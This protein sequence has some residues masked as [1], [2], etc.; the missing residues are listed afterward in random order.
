MANLIMHPK[1]G[2][3]I[4][5]E[6]FAGIP[7][8]E[9]T[10]Y[11]MI[12]AVFV[13]LCRWIQYLDAALRKE[14][15]SLV[16]VEATHTED[17][18]CQTSYSR[19]RYG[20]LDGTYAN[21][22]DFCAGRCRHNSESV[23]HENAYISEFHHCYSVPSNSSGANSTYL[24]GRLNGINILVGR[25][26]KSC[27]SVC[28]SNGQSCVPNK[29]PVLNQCDIMQKYMRSEGDCLASIG[30][31][32][33]AEVVDS[34][35]KHLTERRIVFILVTVRIQEDVCILE[36]NQY[37]LVMVHISIREGY[38][39][40]HSALTWLERNYYYLRPES[41]EKGLKFP[42]HQSCYSLMAK[43]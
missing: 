9:D 33:P 14:I 20:D 30:A 22:F 5:R 2:Y 3:W 4:P 12:M 8:K 10:F 40:V 24:E 23:V 38:A 13:M 35:P 19:S 21:V 28:K 25:Q 43:F 27:D 37:F 18:D 15:N 29:L 6:A 34:A 26:G 32:Q 1:E 36:H 41:F 11:L 17:E 16:N 39:L 31:D 42:K 7:F